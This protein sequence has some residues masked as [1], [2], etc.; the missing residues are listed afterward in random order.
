MDRSLPGSS[1]QNT[2]KNTGVGCHFLLQRIFPTQ[3]S[4]PS[5]LHLLHC[6]IFPMEKEGTAL[7]PTFGVRERV[8]TDSCRSFPHASLSWLRAN[9]CIPPRS[10]SHLRGNVPHLCLGRG[11]TCITSLL[12]WPYTVNLT[13]SIQAFVS[14]Y[15]VSVSKVSL[16]SLYLNYFYSFGIINRTNMVFGAR[17]QDSLQ[18]TGGFYFQ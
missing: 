15:P 16:R 12:W 10:V 11:H 6:F 3:G 13:H 9:V 18:Y 5:L 17:D 7:G 14:P 2:G 8:T 1:V 4:N